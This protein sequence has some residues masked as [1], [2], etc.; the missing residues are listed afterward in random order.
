MSYRIGIDVGG[1]FTDFLL[2]GPD[3]LRLVHKTS[4]TPDDP[5]V[6]FAAGLAE[7]ATLLGVEL[8]SLLR[9]TEVMVHGT[10]VTTNAVLTRR[11][12]TTGL[13][14]TRG[15]RDALALRNGLRES[16]YD[17]RLQP[18]EPLVPRYLRAGI[19]ERT[20]YAGDEVVALAEDDVR[21]ACELFRTEGVEE[22]SIVA[23]TEKQGFVDTH[24]PAAQR[25]NDPF[26][27]WGRT[28]GDQRRPDR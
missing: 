3:D 16:P 4:S 26:V 5:S 14:A 25:E 27:G 2:I 7:I 12:A 19:E 10:T 8:R 20:D 22:G 18:P 9:E 6:G 17:N 28:R 15:F 13:L 23:A 24:A 1:T 11:G 21:A